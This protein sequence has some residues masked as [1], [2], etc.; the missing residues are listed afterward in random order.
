[1]TRQWRFD[2]VLLHLPIGK[3]VGFLFCK[4]MSMRV[5]GFVWWIAIPTLVTAVTP[6]IATFYPTNVYVWSA[7]AVAIGGAVVSAIAAVRAAQTQPPPGAA[8]IDAPAVKPRGFAKRWL[9]GA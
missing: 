5:P 1:M 4:E 6:V 3:P 8:S 9:L 2:I 7:L